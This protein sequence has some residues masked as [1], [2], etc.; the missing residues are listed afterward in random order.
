MQ[1]CPNCGKLIIPEC[2]PYYDHTLCLCPLCKFVFYKQKF[3][4][5][6]TCPACD[7]KFPG[8]IAVPE[9]YCPGKPYKELP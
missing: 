1:K 6:A 2:W 4:E 9:H 8:W 3:T 7:K 5:E